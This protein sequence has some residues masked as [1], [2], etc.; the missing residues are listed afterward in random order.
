MQGTEVA[1]G[2][3]YEIYRSDGKSKV[4]VG[5]LQKH[6]LE[7]LLICWVKVNRLLRCFTVW[8]FIIRCFIHGL[9][10]RFLGKLKY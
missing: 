9:L 6:S 4:K 1:K 10:M 3:D 8:A 5:N 7:I 2:L